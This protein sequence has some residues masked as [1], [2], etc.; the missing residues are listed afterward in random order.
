LGRRKR[1]QTAR[2]CWSD[3]GRLVLDREVVDLGTEE[4][5]QHPGRVEPRT[6]R[7][8]RT[9]TV[10]T[11]A[12]VALPG[13]VDRLLEQ[14]P[15]VP[16]E[17][18]VARAERIAAMRDAALG[19][20]RRADAVGLRGRLAQHYQ[21]RTSRSAPAMSAG[22]V[23]AHCW[24]TL[25]MR[26]LGGQAFNRLV[27]LL[28]FDSLPS[29]AGVREATLAALGALAEWVAEAPAQRRRNRPRRHR[30]A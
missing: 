19:F 15:A 9:G 16:G 27:D 28:V 24:L 22:Q 7:V 5:R 1:K 11:G 25:A 21:V 12:I 29:R 17:P 3:D 8:N 13:A 18:E 20:M 6:H 4:R 14:A 10:V 2:L 23:R 30:I 26:R